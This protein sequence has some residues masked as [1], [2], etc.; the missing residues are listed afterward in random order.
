MVVIPDALVAFDNSQEPAAYV[1]IMSIGHL[2]EEEN[3]TISAAVFQL[4]A[5]LGIKDTR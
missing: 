3:V 1:E 2:G 5:K 4:L